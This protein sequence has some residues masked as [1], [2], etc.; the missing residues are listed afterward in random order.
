MKRQ[1]RMEGSEPGQHR[2]AGERLTK[3]EHRVQ[4]LQEE[5]GQW[6]KTLGGQSKTFRFRST[7]VWKLSSSA[8]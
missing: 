1:A 8:R 4:G 2:R 7:S 6:R 3:G 5:R